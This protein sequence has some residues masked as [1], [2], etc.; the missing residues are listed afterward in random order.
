M[1]IRDYEAVY[2]VDPTLDNEQL[3]PIIEKYRQVVAD[4]GGEVVSAAVWEK[5]RLAY[6]VKG[7]TEGIYIVMNYK[8]E[9][10][11]STELD[12]VMK[13]SEDVMR[14]IIVRDEVP[15]QPKPLGA[16]APVAT[17]QPAAE[18]PVVAE[19]VVEEPVAEEPVVEEPV[20]EEPVTEEPVAEEPVAEE[21]AAE[22]PVAEEP[23]AEEVVAEEPAAEE[24]PAAEE[25]ASE[26]PKA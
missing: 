16:E 5:R 24:S 1:A 12:R 13:L 9:P 10:A 21:P 17:A 2:I 8:G 6:E 25:A 18:E 23:V 15:P 3:Q 14:H 26:E 20:T 22:E 19:P 4:N 7:R 11:T